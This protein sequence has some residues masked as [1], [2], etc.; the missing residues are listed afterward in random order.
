[1]GSSRHKC[2]DCKHYI[3]AVAAGRLGDG[4]IG[5]NF[6]FYR[7][8]AAGHKSTGSRNIDLIDSIR[9]ADKLARCVIC[10]NRSVV[11]AAAAAVV[12]GVPVDFVIYLAL[13]G[14]S[15]AL[16]DPQILVGDLRKNCYRTQREG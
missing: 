16:E 15:V 13:Y 12:A 3:D 8:F 9:D 4:V 2:F 11:V 6:D 14:R 5:S 1:M 7:R 10:H